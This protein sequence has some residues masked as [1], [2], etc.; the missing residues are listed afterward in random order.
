[1]GDCGYLDADGRLWFCGRKAERVESVAGTLHTEPCEQ[2]FRR[3]PRASRCALI[4]LGER[5]HQRAALVVETAVKDSSE[6]RTLARELRSL[7]LQHAHTE[8]SSSS[9][10]TASPGRRPP[11]RQNPP[12]LPR[13]MGRHRQ[14]V[15]KRSEAIAG[16]K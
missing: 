7:A 8:K 16:D 1:M 10:F 6:A 13:P 5:G 3:H 12:P 2:V 9:I 11:Q 4:G 15:R 14:G